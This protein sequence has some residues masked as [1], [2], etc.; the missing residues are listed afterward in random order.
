MRTVS[1]TVVEVY[2]A[3]NGKYRWRA[4]AR[5]GKVTGQGQAYTRRRDAKRGGQ[6]KHPT[7]AIRIL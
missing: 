6:R 4:R 5:N 2:K 3:G 1:T 7:A